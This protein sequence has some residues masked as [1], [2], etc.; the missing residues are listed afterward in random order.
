MV[1][2]LAEENYHV[3]YFSTDNVFDG[4]KGNYSEKDTTNAINE[5]GKMKEEMEHFL[6]DK[7]PEV[8]IFRLPKV[9]S[10]E[11]EIKNML[12]D[13][14]QRRFDNEIRCI[15]GMRMS[16]VAKDDL[17][18]ACLIAAERKMQGIYHLSSGEIY[19]R[20]ELAA[21]FFER[22]GVGGRNIVELD[23]NEFGFQDKRP[24][25]I[26][27]DN[28]KFRKETGFFFKTYAAMVEQYLEKNS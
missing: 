28:S 17:Y 8:C 6:R 19:S 18:Q 1:G 23:I 22:L 24:L 9:L 7:Y 2:T 21:I 20:K 5:Y 3:I 27:L 15:K 4:M 13:W 14:E 26:G 12:A 16:V 10:A 11:R 25:D